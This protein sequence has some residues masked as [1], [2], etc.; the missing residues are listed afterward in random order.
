M[1]FSDSLINVFA[2]LFALVTA[3]LFAEGKDLKP[4][5]NSSANKFAVTSANKFAN[6]V[7]VVLLN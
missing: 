7:T 1:C 2:N 6:T 5:K 4:F 3:N